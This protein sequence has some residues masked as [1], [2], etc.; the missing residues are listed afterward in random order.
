[1]SMSKEYSVNEPET[2]LTDKGCFEGSSKH[3]VDSSV[4]SNDDVC[5]KALRRSKQSLSRP[6]VEAVDNLE[7]EQQTVENVLVSN[8]GGEESAEESGLTTLRK[9]LE[10]KMS[11]KV[12]LTKCPV[13]VK[14]LFDTG[15][16]DGVPVVYMGTI[17]S[18]T[19]GLRGII[20]DGG[21]LCSCSLFEGR[22][23]RNLFSK[24]RF[25]SFCNFL[26]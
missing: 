24:W 11:K 26:N 12:A 15:L 1:M 21:I 13:T 7:C 9:N 2:S 10:L 16:H 17:S 4:G 20:T 19:A 5:L 22:R 25:W 3:I 18:K 23:V 6:N 14:E 8:F